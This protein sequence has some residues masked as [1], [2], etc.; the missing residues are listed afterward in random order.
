MRLFPLFFGALFICSFSFAQ[1]IQQETR[2]QA[3]KILLISDLNDSYGST[4]YSEEVH[5]VIAKVDAIQPDL[6]L[7]AGDM[8]AGQ[9]KK[10]SVERLDSMW[11]GFQAAVLTPLSEKNIPFGFTMGN[12]DASPNYLHDRQAASKFWLANK[13]KVNL[14]FIDDSHFPYYFSYIKNNVFFISWDASS[15]VIP[16]S[17]KVWMQEQ[18]QAPL[19]KGARG[20]I[21]LGHLSLYAIVE[22][23]NKAGEVLKNADETLSFLKD[24][25]VDMYISGHQHVYYPAAKQQVT[26][27]H[28]GCLGGGPRNLIG[29]TG[30][31][32]KAYSVLEIGRRKSVKKANIQGFVARDHQAIDLQF[33][34]KQVEG[35][36]GS[37]RRI[38]LDN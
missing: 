16:D 22:A 33:L 24:N 1:N 17:V 34:P 13:S 26:L 21:V 36:N 20:R 2:N 3:L 11:S 10:L 8:V 5:D 25:Q 35:F 4:S 28:A 6:V 23:K 38:D 7:C 18:L 32:Y 14:S 31:S 27:L 19:A 30:P 37:V 15:A 29:Q 12:H 9:S